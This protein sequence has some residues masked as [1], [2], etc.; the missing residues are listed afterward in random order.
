VQ[1]TAR[2]IA[3][4]VSQPKKRR[5]RSS[6]TALPK[7]TTRSRVLASQSVQ[8]AAPVS[9][10]S[11]PNHSRRLSFRVA[12]RQTVVTVVP[13]NEAHPLDWDNGSLAHQVDVRP[14]RSAM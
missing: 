3:P 13:A 14:Q 8:Q 9:R 2:P 6:Q 12:N 10:V 11:K 5:Q 7:Q 4:K 1:P